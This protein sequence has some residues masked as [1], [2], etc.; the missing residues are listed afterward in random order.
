MKLKKIGNKWIDKIRGSTVNQHI[1]IC[2]DCGSTKISISEKMIKCKDCGI[3]RR[4]KNTITNLKFQPGDMVRIVDSEKGTKL[5]YKIEKINQ[6]HEGTIHYMLK[7]KSSPIT[8]FY[9]ENS[10]SYL[11]KST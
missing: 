4:R 2:V 6:D 11:E 9:H 8:L 10:E 5:V 1:K 3:S 7:S